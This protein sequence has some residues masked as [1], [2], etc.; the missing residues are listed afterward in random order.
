MDRKYLYADGVNSYRDHGNLVFV[1]LRDRSGL[2]Q[3][4]FDPECDAESHR[5]ARGLRCEW[6]IACE[7]SIPARRRAA[8]PKLATGEIEVIVHR[9]TIVNTAKTLP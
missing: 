6:V 3:V 9:L 7:G 1:D 4:V 8:N 5:L 2:V